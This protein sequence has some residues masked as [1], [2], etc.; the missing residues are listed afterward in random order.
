MFWLLLFLSVI[1]EFLAC[2]APSLA[3]TAT[4]NALGTEKDKYGRQRMFGSL[5][6]GSAMFLVGFAIDALPDYQVITVAVFF[7]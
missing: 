5:G 6:W 3:D 7:L 1:G 4:L 2:P